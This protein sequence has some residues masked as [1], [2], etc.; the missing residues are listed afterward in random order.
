MFNA[1]N[2]IG[3]GGQRDTF[4]VNNAN[5]ALAIT[6][7]ICSLIGAPIYNIFGIRVIIPA[8]LTYVLYVGSYL[9]NN[10]P[11][12]I[13]CG[14]ILGIGA[15][16]L[17]TAEA[18]IMMSYPS[19]TEKGRAFSIFWI[20]F[21]LG[22]MMGAAIPLG[23]EWY[24]T[25]R[26]VQPTTY[27][28]FMI[29]MF[30][31]AI[32]ALALLPANKVIRHDGSVVSLHKFSNWRREMIAIFKLF[33]NWR[34]LILIPLFA[35]SNWFYVYQFQVYN[36]PNYITMHGRTINNFVYWWCQIL[37]AAFFGWLMDWE[38]L[39]RRKSRAYIGNTIVLVTLSSLWIACIFIQR[40][41]TREMVMNP[42]FKEIDI[43]HP[44]YPGMCVLYALFGFADSIY[45]GFIYWLIGTMTNDTERA[46][47]FGGF[48][49]TIQNAANAIASQVDATGTPYMTELAITFAINAIG[50]LLAYVV[51][52]TV[53]D[54]T[55]EEVELADGAVE[56]MVG[57]QIHNMDETSLS[58][59]SPYDDRK[60]NIY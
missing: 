31:G 27:Y 28:A 13:I 50:L 52:W 43:D 51:C 29:V 30:F 18:G 33:R 5:T 56:Q 44:E 40:R 41:F 55:I 60:A 11:F 53:P 45:Q 1:L 58:H 15:G 32:L 38:R 57:G 59:L 49:K 20:V 12:T 22:A 37:G 24:A 14:A 48:Y 17:W 34:M 8:A 6:F 35:G 4:V 7:T 36:G 23:N 19:E 16:C 2:G 42:Q 25:T 54:V 21:N 10:T 46:A 3:G 26:Q 9:A 47:R 39:G